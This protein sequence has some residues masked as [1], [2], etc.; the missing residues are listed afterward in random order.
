MPVAAVAL[1]LAGLPT[2]TAEQTGSVIFIHPDGASSATWAAA[3]AYHVGPDSDLNWDRLPHIALYRGHMIDSLT[4][5]S[6]GG[7]TTHATGI[8]VRSSAFG[9]F[10]SGKDAPRITDA[11]GNYRSVAIE[12]LAAGLR[13]G[14][15]QSGTAIE[16]GTAVFL[17][18][19]DSRQK[20]D[21]IALG[22][23]TSG[24]HVI[25]GGGEQHFLPRG[26]EGVHG[27]GKRRD[28]KNL[29][30]H[31]RSLGYT[32][33]RT[34]DE[35]LAL[36]ADTDKVLGL[37]A[38][39]HTFNDKPEEVLQAAGLP[40]YDPEAPTLAEMTE[41]ALRL[42]SRNGH[43]FLLVLEEEGPDNFGNNNNAGG[44][45]EA[46][47]RTDDAFG[48]ARRFLVERPDTLIVTAADSDGGG[49]RMIG[50]RIDPDHPK[51]VEDLRDVPANDRN[52]A[53]QD[54]IAGPNSKPFLA[55][56]DRNGVRL[57]FSIVWA[58][59]K[60]VAGGV[61]VRAEGLNAKHVHGSFDNTQIAELIRLTLFG[62]NAQPPPSPPAATVPATEADSMAASP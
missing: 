32:V 4:A 37:F 46:L 17:T 7:A 58:T 59:G 9:K 56:P 53:P 45:L 44:T 62:R 43:Q 26:T 41:V 6:N 33:I 28:D 5:T 36:P 14:V 55:A 1:M 30:E 3:R 18:D 42:L 15:V 2:A 48:V 20:H 47:K 39:Y 54:G 10:A 11:N 24:A 61:L 49:M 23:L 31:A 51:P 16:P 22:L 29:V 40:N 25:L 13:V 50:V 12:A 38:S 34:R 35:L 60:D 8:K 27:P 57:P 52:G 21:D 19:A